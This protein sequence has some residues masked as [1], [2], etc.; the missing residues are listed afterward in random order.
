MQI[1]LNFFTKKDGKE[2]TKTKIEDHI[3]YTLHDSTLRKDGG[4]GTWG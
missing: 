3:T 1:L 4:K 2:A